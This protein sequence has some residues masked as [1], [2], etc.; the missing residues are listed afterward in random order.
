V[1]LWQE[2]VIQEKKELDEK[3]IKLQ[4]FID[5]EEIKTIDETESLRLE[6]QLT[7]MQGYSNILEA[8]I[9][10]WDLQTSAIEGDAPKTGQ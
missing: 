3:I 1:E 5:G 6:V 10:S 4:T 7:L 9:T 8:R 2:R